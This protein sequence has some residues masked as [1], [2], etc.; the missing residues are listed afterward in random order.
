M[1]RLKDK[2][3]NSIRAALQK[4]FDIKNPMLIPAL[5]KIVINVGTGESSKDQKVFQNMADTISL[6]AGQKALIVN[7]KKSVAGFKVREG[8]LVGIMVTLRKEQM[9]AFLDKLIS[10][11]LPRVKDFRGLPRAGL[12]DRKSVV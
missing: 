5:E 3:D 7:A 1:S 9:F 10:I 12:R 2:Y 11:T 4:E 8:F 6:I